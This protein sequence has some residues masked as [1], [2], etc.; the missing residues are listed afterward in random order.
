M[1]SLQDRLRQVRDLTDQ[2]RRL[3]LA[4]PDLAG[5]AEAGRIDVAVI[6]EKKRGK[7]TFLN[8]LMGAQVFPS[9]ATVCTAA[10]TVL[11]HAP[12]PTLRI[13]YQDGRKPVESRPKDAVSLYDGVLA[14]VAVAKPDRKTGATTGNPDAAK[15]ERVEIGFPNR[16]AT[17]GVRLIDTPG[18]N[19][20][21]TWR[22][23]I[24]FTIL[25]S[26][27]VDAVIMLLDPTQPF[28]E[29]DRQFLTTQVQARVKEQ[30][31]FVVNKIDG[32]TP[33]DRVKSLERI[34]R[35][36]GELVPTP[37][38]FPLSA[39]L[40]F[41][42][43]QD[44]GAL[45]EDWTGFT[46]ALDRFL[47]AG[48]AGAMLADRALQI[49]QTAD[50]AIAT[51][52]YRLT[53]LDQDDATAQASLAAVRGE[54]VTA[55]QRLESLERR[56]KQRAEQ[57]GRESLA[58]LRSQLQEIRTAAANPQAVSGIIHI[59]RRDLTDLM[60][61][62]AKQLVEVL[63]GE[64]APEIQAACGG[65]DLTVP[66]VTLPASG[67]PEYLGALPPTHRPPAIRQAQGGGAFAGAAIGMWFGP[68][69]ALIGGV[70]GHMAEHQDRQASGLAAQMAYE[71]QVNAARTAM[72]QHL[73]ALDGAIA[74]VS[75]R[76]LTAATT[77]TAKAL[78]QPLVEAIREAEH[79]VQAT[80][81]DL[82][83]AV[84]GRDGTRRQLTA[85]QARLTSFQAL[86]DRLYCELG[87]LAAPTRAV[88]RT[89]H[90]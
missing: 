72:R 2:G 64:F 63:H 81:R 87:S 45:P 7:S 79:R 51:L 11:E 43:Q 22:E 18:V 23:E 73:D 24:T 1:I 36:A 71:Q 75:K 82:G 61:E 49:R 70:L 90:A 89:T 80:G 32:V 85:E 5:N 86:A 20:P 13:V 52:R 56:M 8:A 6:G 17:D 66:T 58:V 47:Q 42:A 48:R 33:A 9:R 30:I 83:Q 16:F 78:R 26:G 35:L 84:D 14:A 59:V 41:T 38:V 55:R 77:Q 74:E 3:G 4:I 21:D 44:G 57:W 53:A 28:S 27:R 69:G 68:L 54:L 88:T 34:T 15:V 60:E 31:L 76:L 62:H 25:G 19:D 12:E 10:V 40:A 46:A 37:R 65:L 50:A 29:S 67:L 39:K